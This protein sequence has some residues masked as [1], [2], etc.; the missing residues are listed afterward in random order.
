MSASRSVAAAQRRRA[1]P[2]EPQQQ[3]R[4]PNT[5][6][7][8]SQVFNQQQT[9]QMRPGTTG[10]LAGQQAAYAQQQ[11]QQQQIPNQNQ[12]LSQK[13]P[14][15]K[16]SIAQAITLITLRLGRIENKL[17]ELDENPQSYINENG[18][19]IDSNIIE[20]I[21]QRLDILEQQEHPSTDVSLDIQD[22]ILKF[23]Q[24][25]ETFKTSITSVRNSSVVYN[26]DIKSFKNEL[27]IL[28]NDLFQTKSI[29]DE[30]HLIYNEKLSIAE[31]NDEVEYIEDGIVNTELENSIENDINEEINNESIN[32]DFPEQ[33]STTL[34]EENEF[35]QE[36]ESELVLESEPVVNDNIS[37]KELIQQELTMSGVCLGLPEPK[38]GNHTNKRS[39]KSHNKK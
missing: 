38:V 30:L 4:G 3:V 6:I 21:L 10:R 12:K 24:Q 29:V 35:K 36:S 16:M 27:D 19:V 7:N 15:S 2:V 1:G 9:Q 22:E 33:E 11:Y 20:N 31:A 32:N 5:S 39:G 8:S 28:K 14:G 18:E 23:K 25:L 34:K 17:S 37:L 26:K 13:T